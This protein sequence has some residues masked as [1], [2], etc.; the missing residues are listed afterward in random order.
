VLKSLKQE[1][2]EKVRIIGVGLDDTKEAAEAFAQKEKLPWPNIYHRDAADD[3]ARRWQVRAIP[4]VIVIDAQGRIRY[5]GSTGD[6][7]E[8][9]LERLIDTEE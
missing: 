8:H 3:P 7:L 2:G 5:R 1:Y 4:A 9:H 6:A